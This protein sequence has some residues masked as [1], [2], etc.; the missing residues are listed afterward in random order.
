MPAPSQKSLR[1]FS[2]VNAS[3]NEAPKNS[4]LGPGFGFYK[5]LM[6]APEI[7]WKP[8]I[9]PQMKPHQK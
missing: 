6:S 1:A 3:A 2:I 4:R 5:N 7:L 8:G 9:R